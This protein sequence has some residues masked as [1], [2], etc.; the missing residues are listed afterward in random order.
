MI[1]YGFPSRFKLRLDDWTAEVCHRFFQLVSKYIPLSSLVFFKPEVPTKFP[2]IEDLIVWLKCLHEGE[3]CGAGR[4]G[5]KME[6][7]FASY[8]S[9]NYSSDDVWA[10][11]K[12]VE[13]MRGLP[14][15]MVEKHIID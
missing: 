6:C 12:S 3:G 13:Y 10:M 14:W 15:P 2:K 8:D 5:S 11:F 7:S 9:Q 1:F 4:S